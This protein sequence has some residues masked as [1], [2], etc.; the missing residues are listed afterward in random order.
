MKY[1]MPR[2]IATMVIEVL[3]ENSPAPVTTAG[4]KIKMAKVM[5][6]SFI[7]LS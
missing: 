7:F 6:K 2:I 5:S 4:T 1:L 3:I